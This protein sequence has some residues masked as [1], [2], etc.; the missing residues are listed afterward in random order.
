MRAFSKEHETSF[1]AEVIPKLFFFD[2]GFLT[3]VVVVAG[4][5]TGVADVA[6]K[7]ESFL[8]KKTRRRLCPTRLACRNSMNETNI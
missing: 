1:A 4:A 5:S 8:K 6:E 7:F 3:T 2:A